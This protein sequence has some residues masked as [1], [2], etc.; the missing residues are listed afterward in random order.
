MNMSM[1]GNAVSCPSPWLESN[2]Q[3]SSQHTTDYILSQRLSAIAHHAKKKRYHR[4]IIPLQITYPLKKYSY[5]KSMT[6]CLQ[7]CTVCGS[8]LKIDP[9]RF[10]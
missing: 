9:T 8:R 6:T 2:L 3:C 7:K 4:I 1:P 10:W 5:I